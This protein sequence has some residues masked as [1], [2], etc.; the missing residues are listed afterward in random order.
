M[1]MCMWPMESGEFVDNISSKFIILLLSLSFD[2][3]L[4]KQNTHRP[5]IAQIINCLMRNRLVYLE[6][7]RRTTCS[8]CLVVPVS[9]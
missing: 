3:V 1:Y 2:F 5:I 4:Y 8:V 7:G 9:E 6:L